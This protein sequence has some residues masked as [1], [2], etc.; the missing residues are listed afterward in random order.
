M[1]FQTI[2]VS[3]VATKELK[4][5]LEQWSR[6]EDRTVSAVLRRILEGEAKR[7]QYQQSSKQEVSYQTH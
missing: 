3:F 5:L 7:R 2:T 1:S 6:E 4:Q